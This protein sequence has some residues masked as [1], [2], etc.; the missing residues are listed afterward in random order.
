MR[1]ERASDGSH[2]DILRGD[3]RGRGARGTTPSPA[4]AGR[5]EGI[6]RAGWK[7]ETK[8]RGGQ[9][10]PCHGGGGRVGMGG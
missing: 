8:E 9:A 7:M 6:W 1:A 5:I 10:G 2:L 3:W 4:L